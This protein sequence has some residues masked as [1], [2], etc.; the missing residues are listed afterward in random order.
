LY[1]N[2][3]PTQTGELACRVVDEWLIPSASRM[4]RTS[5]LNVRCISKR[6]GSES[7]KA[8]HNRCITTRGGTNRAVSW[9]TQ[10]N[11]ITGRVAR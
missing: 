8:R 10:S 6:Q 4:T 5:G 1:A 9:F 2:K 3:L 11:P 7:S